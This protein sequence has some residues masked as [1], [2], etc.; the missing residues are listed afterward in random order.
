MGM[1]GEVVGTGV[2]EEEEEEEGGVGMVGGREKVVV[3]VE[4]SRSV[5]RRMRWAQRSCKCAAACP[6]DKSWTLVTQT[7]VARESKRWLLQTGSEAPDSSTSN[8]QSM[9]ATF[10]RGMAVE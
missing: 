2:E 3:P 9:A 10:I 1:M 6:I 7:G 8:A 5:K 4:L